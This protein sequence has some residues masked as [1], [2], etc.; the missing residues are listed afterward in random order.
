MALPGSQGAAAASL[1]DNLNSVDLNTQDALRRAGAAFQQP[2][3]TT[4][5]FVEIIDEQ[6][7][8]DKFKQS[9]EYNNLINYLRD[10]GLGEMVDNMD[11]DTLMAAIGPNGQITLE[12]E[13][14]AD[15]TD[16]AIRETTEGLGFLSN[17][18]NATEAD[19]S[20]V[21][22]ALGVNLRTATNNLG[23][24]LLI[25]AGLNPMDRNQTFLPDLS[26]SAL[27][28]QE[29]NATA[30][31]MLEAIAG[32]EAG[33]L[34]TGMIS[35]AIQAFA[36]YEIALGNSPDLA[37]LSGVF[38]L[39]E[40]L[41]QLTGGDPEKERILRGQIESAYGSA[42]RQM[43]EEYGI[44]AGRLRAIYNEAGG[45]SR[46]ITALDEQLAQ[47][48][49]YMDAIAGTG[50][51]EFS[52]RMSILDEASGG[53]LYKS[54]SLQDA[55]LN[56]LTTEGRMQAERA[57]EGG[58]SLAAVI[59]AAAGDN[60]YGSFDQQQFITDFISQEAPGD[61][62]RNATLISIDRHIQMLPEQIGRQI[63]F[64]DPERAPATGGDIWAAIDAPPG[65]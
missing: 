45:G 21:A 2:G 27:G 51:M 30:S 46:G 65:R 9:L 35:D 18:L 15:E 58:T 40:K 3:P 60:T 1:V 55:F 44:D 31:A 6:F 64:P 48:K 12:L 8:K 11:F 36:A 28:V 42:F 43:E 62:E 54:R 25:Q 38:E 37:A 47:R 10:A 5:P 7:L 52:K 13:R 14:R 20:R 19:I 41:P 23:A 49:E 57:L 39:E 22:Q 63:S 32:A 17:A 26:T 61:V 4:L 53:E 24:Q 50:G 34:N 33:D 29:K 56:N 59:D 16:R